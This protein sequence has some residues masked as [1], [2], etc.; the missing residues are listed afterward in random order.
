M[1]KQG[2]LLLQAVPDYKGPGRRRT[3]AR[4]RAHADASRRAR[5][6]K[7]A[8]RRVVAPEQVAPTDRQVALDVL[9]LLE[10]LGEAG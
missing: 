1:E 10:E 9:A 4:V 2:T 6:R 3:R 8:E 7:W 5:L